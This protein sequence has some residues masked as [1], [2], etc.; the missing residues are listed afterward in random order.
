MMISNQQN[1]NYMSPA[2]AKTG[3]PVRKG[4]S[5]RNL[6]APS[7]ENLSKGGSVVAKRG[8]LFCTTTTPTKDPGQMMIDG[9]E[10][11]I[12]FGAVGLAEQGKA[13]ALSTRRNTMLFA[14]RKASL[15]LLLTFCGC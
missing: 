6:N 14:V 11:E 10:D 2:A 8:Q 7:V 12:F 9:E 15:L 13:D 4:L 5:A 1:E 3:T